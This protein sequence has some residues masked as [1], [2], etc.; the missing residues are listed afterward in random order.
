MRPSTRLLYINSTSPIGDL[1]TLTGI[2]GATLYE[3]ISWRNCPSPGPR[4]YLAL[5][6]TD[7]K[8]P[9]GTCSQE[10]DVDMKQYN[11][12]QDWNPRESQDGR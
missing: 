5:L 2:S 3:E 6:Q 1:S 7:A 4:K 12:V 11:L 9:L 10:G 8:G